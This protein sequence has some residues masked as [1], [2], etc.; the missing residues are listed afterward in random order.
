MCELLAEAVVEA[1][2]TADG[3]VLM[4]TIILYAVDA[5]VVV[6]AAAVV[7]FHSSFLRRSIGDDDEVDSCKYLIIDSYIMHFLSYYRLG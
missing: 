3:R 6:A 5:A 2:A 7:A 1:V 4:E